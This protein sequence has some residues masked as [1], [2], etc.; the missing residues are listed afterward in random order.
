MNAAG[1]IVCVLSACFGLTLPLGAQCRV[2]L[3]MKLGDLEAAVR[4]DSDDAAAH[5]NVG[6]AYCAAERYD[7]A[8]REFKQAVAIE[9]QFAEPYL[10]LS[11]L[12]FA[13]RPRLFRDQYEH[14]LPD[15]WVPKLKEADHMYA[16]AF[17]VDPFVDVKIIGAVTPHDF[18][19]NAEVGEF[20]A[21]FLRDLFDGVDFFSEGKY[22]RAY[23]SF[24]RVY[25]ELHVE[26]RPGNVPNYLLWYHGIAAGHIQ[27]YDDAIWDIQTILNRFEQAEKSDSLIRIPLETNDFRYILACLKQRAGKLQDAADLFR[28][29]LEHDAGLY[30]AHTRLAQLYESVQRW[31]VAISE[32]RAAV[33]A[34]PDD[35]SLVYDLGVTLA[36]G[37]QWPQADSTLRQAMDANPR[38]SRVPYYLGIVEQQLGKKDEARTA[39]QRFLALAPSRYQAQ[40]DNAKQRLA[41]LQ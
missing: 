24:Q 2:K 33:N 7:D 15:E 8:E 41:A 14:S 30:M 27:K 20:Y 36:K 18:G 35:P 17:L 29:A 26:A 3:P 37:A 23:T 38:D 10:A 34:N 5:Y 39:F 6:V 13:R 1:R 21:E 25:N 9:P 31:P 19:V 11:Q 22:D 28:S 4:R 16:R 40:I 12:P 32:R